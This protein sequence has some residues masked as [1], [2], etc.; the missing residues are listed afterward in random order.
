MSAIVI[1]STSGLMGALMREASSSKNSIPVSDT[2]YRRDTTPHPLEASLLSIMGKEEVSRQKFEMGVL[3]FRII[4]MQKD[5]SATLSEITKWYQENHPEI[6]EAEL[7]AF[8]KKAIFQQLKLTGDK[9]KF[10]PA[11]D[12]VSLRERSNRSSKPRKRLPKRD[13][14]HFL[15][16]LNALY[17]NSDRHKRWNKMFFMVNGTP[18]TPLFIPIRTDVIY[19][20]SEGIPLGFSYDAVVGAFR[21]VYIPTG[22]PMFSYIYDNPLDAVKARMVHIKMLNWALEPQNIAVMYQQWYGS[23]EKYDAVFKVLHK[24][25]FGEDPPYY[26]KVDGIFDAENYYPDWRDQ[27]AERNTLLTSVGGLGGIQNNSAWTEKSYNDRISGQD[28]NYLSLKDEYL[29][30]YDDYSGRKITKMH[31]PDSGQP[32]SSTNINQ[33]KGREIPKPKWLTTIEK[34]I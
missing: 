15:E 9:G 27:R 5:A 11:G 7:N 26:I 31:Y 13:V 25:M 16:G 30:T 23:P 10:S 19:N 18:D 21:V 28:K 20:I 3:G 12:Y 22:D 24:E 8:I 6:N 33:S 1:G 4:N 17:K 2:V 34:K 14:N 32:F 29:K